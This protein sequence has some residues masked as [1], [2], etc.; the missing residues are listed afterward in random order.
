MSSPRTVGSIVRVLI[1]CHSVL[2]AHRQML[3]SIK[4]K[5]EDRWTRLIEADHDWSKDFYFSHSLCEYFFALLYFLC[6][7]MSTMIKD[8]RKCTTAISNLKFSC[9]D[10]FQLRQLSWSPQSVIAF[11]SNRRTF[12]EKRLSNFNLI[13]LAVLSTTC[14]HTFILIV[15]IIINHLDHISIICNRIYTISKWYTCT[16]RLFIYF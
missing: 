13:R 11:M 5:C 1:G 8:K 3:T 4:K 2:C 10:L 12:S 6:I 9:T 14:Y 15:V 16:Q 7:Y